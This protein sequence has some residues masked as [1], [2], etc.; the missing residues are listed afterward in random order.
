[1]IEVTES[2]VGDTDH[3]RSILNGLRDAGART[4]IDDFG[5]GFSSLGRINSLPFDGLKL[6][7]EFVANLDEPQGLGIARAIVSI[8]DALHI[9]VIA[10][11]IETPQQLEQ[12][13]ELGC[14]FGQG[15]LLGRPAPFA[16]R[17]T[18]RR[19]VDQAFTPRSTIG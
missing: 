5:T 2:A 4:W 9:P 10:E 6:A 14:A 7:R 11:G 8:A 17:E 18:W 3:A 15:Y 1:V 12:V 13:R 16:E 19:S